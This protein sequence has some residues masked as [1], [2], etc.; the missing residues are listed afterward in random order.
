MITQLV[1][2]PESSHPQNLDH[3]DVV[4]CGGGLAGMCLARQLKLNMPDISILVLDKLSSPLPVAA[5]KVGES[6]VEAG[7]YYLVN[8][9]QLG[10]YFEEEHYIKLGLRFFH[11]N[12]EGAFKDR[13]EV[14]LSQ[15]HEPHSFQIDRGVVEQH[16]RDLNVAANITVLENCSVKDITL[17]DNEQFHTVYYKQNNTKE[18]QAVKALW[19]IDAMGRRRYIQRKLGLEKPN[20]KQYN[21]A[22]FRI[23]ERI[24]VADLVPETEQEWHN[25]VP[26]KMRFYSTNHL[27]GKGYWVWLIPLSSGYTSIGIVAREDIQPF[28]EFHTQEKALNWLEKHEPALAKHLTERQ[29]TDFKKMPN[30]SYSSNQVFSNNRWSCIGEAG[31]FADPL[32]S[33]GTDMIGHANTITTELIKLDFDGKLTPQIVDEANNLFLSFHEVL[34]SLIQ[35]NYQVFGKNPLI[36]G[37]K[38]VWDCTLGW[39]YVMSV[40]FN[41]LFVHPEKIAKMQNILDKMIGLV[42]QVEYLLDDWSNKSLHKLTFDYIDHLSLPFLDELRTRNLQSNKTD[43]ELISDEIANLEVCEEFAQVLFL[44]AIEDTMPEK[45]GMF[46]EGVWLNAWAIGLDV[47]KWEQDGLFQPQTQPR[48][49]N[50]VMEPVRNRIRL[51]S[52]AT[53]NITPNLR[54]LVTLS[55]TNFL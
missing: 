4:I 10:K 46:P 53:T 32:Y 38:F 36:G 29:L 47:D 15:F 44:L 35:F 7:A 37:I 54:Q 51:N 31:T 41:S 18:T 8:T 21:A 48:D 2:K 12:T 30:Y 39:G 3:Y 6:T 17:A 49:L 25:R 43:E 16:L 27:I 28:E 45:L 1:D 9:L 40:M 13:S 42:K 26:N 52:E 24:D 23:N 34:S 55:Y 19:V 14:G 5:F 20:E 11:G 50:R 22:W 33:P